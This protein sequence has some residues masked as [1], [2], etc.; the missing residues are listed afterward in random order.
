MLRILCCKPNPL[1]TSLFNFAASLQG[2]LLGHP[3]MQR[4]L[5][6]TWMSPLHLFAAVVELTRQASLAS[7]WA[8]CAFSVE[9]CIGHDFDPQARVPIIKEEVSA[10][11]L[12]RKGCRGYARLCPIWD[13]HT[14]GGSMSHAC[15]CLP[16]NTD[17]ACI[18]YISYVR[19]LYMCINFNNLILYVK[20]KWHQRGLIVRAHQRTSC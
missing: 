1:H 6:S 12:H 16:C 9:L 11:P 19:I 14:G 7:R 4:T 13:P 20:W 15:Q 3:A 10:E 8:H 18:W 2:T 17:Y 5:A